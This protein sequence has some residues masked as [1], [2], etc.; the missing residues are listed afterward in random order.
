M[1]KNGVTLPDFP[2]GPCDEVIQRKIS[3][4]IDYATRSGTTFNNNLKTK[5]D[6]GNPHLL[7]KVVDY[8]D[9]DEMGSNFPKDKFDPKAYPDEAFYEKQK[10]AASPTTTTTTTTTTT[11]SETAADK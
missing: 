2:D 10:W 8:F 7:S 1:K 5:K 6:F 9:I 3:K 4:F 11:K